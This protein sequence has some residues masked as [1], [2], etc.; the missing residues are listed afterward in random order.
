MIIPFKPYERKIGQEV[1]T[2][3]WHHLTK[4]AKKLNRPTKQFT[5]TFSL[6]PNPTGLGHVLLHYIEYNKE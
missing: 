6:V 1:E 4:L 3:L 2:E 5:A